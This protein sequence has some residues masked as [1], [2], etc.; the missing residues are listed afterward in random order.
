MSRKERLSAVTADAVANAKIGIGMGY[1]D[2]PHAKVGSMIEIQI[3]GQTVPA[4]I[5]KGRFVTK[6]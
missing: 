3:R 5:V 1:V 2:S 4:E 6:K